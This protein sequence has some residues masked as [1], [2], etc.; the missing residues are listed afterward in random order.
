M[1]TS[2]TVAELEL[3]LFEDLLFQREDIMDKL[4]D[5]HIDQRERSSMRDRLVE[6]NKVFGFEP[7]LGEDPL[8]DSWERDLE[9]GKIPDLSTTKTK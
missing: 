4:R 8:I 7:D 3:E 5:S 9:D 2:Q 6:I 1:F